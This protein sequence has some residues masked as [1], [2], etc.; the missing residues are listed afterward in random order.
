MVIIITALYWNFHNWCPTL[1][2][3]ITCPY[4]WFL[5]SMNSTQYDYISKNIG[6]LF[7]VNGNVGMLTWWRWGKWLCCSLT[8]RRSPH[9][10]GTI[11][12]NHD[13]IESILLD[14]RQKAT[15]T[16]YSGDTTRSSF[17]S[18]L[19]LVSS[20]LVK[21]EAGTCHDI[22]WR[23]WGEFLPHMT[24]HVFNFNSSILIKNSSTCHLFVLRMKC[25][26]FTF[27][28]GGVNNND[29]H[30]WSR[31]CW[32]SILRSYSRRLSSYSRTILNVIHL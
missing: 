12:S 25:K 1:A 29:G 18:I 32:T 6:Y 24:E 11:N 9:V 10:P 26:L 22:Y 20:I 27:S 2:D 28:L 14:D 15:T 16:T 17:I 8:W 30:S 19:W 13:V 21:Y 3:K 4:K 31:M 7:W 5:T 23:I